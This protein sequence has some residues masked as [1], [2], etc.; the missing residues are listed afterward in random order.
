MKAILA[1]SG[2]VSLALL[3]SWNVVPASLASSRPPEWMGRLGW[4]LVHSLWQLTGVAVIAALLEIFLRRRSANVRYIAAVAVLAAMVVPPCVT[5]TLIDVSQLAGTVAADPIGGRL[6]PP[7]QPSEKPAQPIKNSS[8]SRL[9][10]ALPGQPLAALDPNPSRK[11]GR[12]TSPLPPEVPSNVI[13]PKAEAVEESMGKRVIFS[14]EIPELTAWELLVERARLVVEPNLPRLVWLWLAG[15][16]VCSLRPVWGLWIQWQL[17]RIGLSPVSDELQRT[18]LQLTRR[19]GL[20]RV[21]RLAES[22]CVTVPMVVGYVRPMILLPASVL[23]GLSLTQLE[24]LLAHELAHVRRHDWLINAM[25]VVVETL[26][27]YHP[28]VWWLSSR[29]RNERE[30]CCDDIALAVLGDRATYARMLLTVEELRDAKPVIAIAGPSLFAATGGD[31]VHRVR[32]LLPAGSNTER[33]SRG[34]LSGSLLLLTLGILGGVSVFAVHGQN[35]TTSKQPKPDPAIAKDVPDNSLK[36]E[37]SDNRVKDVAEEESAVP[38]NATTKPKKTTADQKRTVRVVDESK[39]PIAGATVRFQFEGQNTIFPGFSMFNDSAKTN[40]KGEYSEEIP[41]GAERVHITVKADGFGEF[42]DGQP[43]SA[44]SSVVELKKGRVIR[45]RAVDSEHKLLK[46]AVPLLSNNRTFGREFVPQPDGTFT[47]PPVALTRRMMRVCA[48]QENGPT[49]FSELID[50]ATAKPG[51]DGVIEL[52]LKPGVRLTGRLADAVPR[53]IS[54]GYVDLFIADG[55][56]H[57]FANDAFRWEDSTPVQTDG[58]F[59]FESIPGG[60]HAQFHVVVDGYLSVNPTSESILEYVQTYHAAS[61]QM[62]NQYREM[63]KD[64]L[65]EMWPRFVRLDRPEVEVTVECEKTAS[66]D[67]HIVDS[68]GNP[69]PNAVV[70][71]SPNGV[72]LSCGL[73]IPGAQT[74]SSAE[75]VD[76]LSRGSATINVFGSKDTSPRAVRQRKEREWAEKSFLR[77]KSDAQGRVQ[78]RNLPGHGRESFSV[79]ADGYVLPRSPLYQRAGDERDD[80]RREGYVNLIAGE[81]N[82]ATITLERDLKVVEREVLMVDDKGRPQSKVTVAVA[83]MRVGPKDWQLWSTQ[84]FG[85]LPKEVTDENGRVLLK[86]PSLIGNTQV[87]RLRLA[88]NYWSGRNDDRIWVNGGLVEAPLI[89]DE[90]VIVLVPNSE[91]SRPGNVVYGKLEDILPK[92]TTE[93]LLAVM[94]EQPSLAVLRQLLGATKTKQPEP[95]ELLAEKRFL[96]GEKTMQV[97]QTKVI[98]SGDSKLAVVAARVRPADGTR[99]SVTDPIELPECAFVFDMQ[100][101]L[102]AA[103]GGHVG[104]TGA[105]SPD[106]IDVLSLG[107]E[108]DWFV[109]TVRFQESGAFEYQTEYYR[110][111]NPV[112]KSLKYIHYANSNGWST[113]PEKITRWGTLSF[114]FP[115]SKDKFDSPGHSGDGG[116]AHTA[117]GVPVLRTMTWD[118]DRNLFIGAAAQFGKGKPLYQVDLDWSREFLPIDLKSNQLFVTGGEREYDHW[119]GWHTVVPDQ[120]ELLLTIT[121]PQTKGEPKVIEKRLAPGKRHVQ[122]QLKPNKD[123]SSARLELRL[124]SI[125]PEMMELP[126]QLGDRPEKHPPMTQILNPGDSARLLDRK[127]KSSTNALIVDIK[128]Q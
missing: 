96:G 61:E 123:N 28:A 33:A 128:L 23:T 119:H 24:L 125:E 84:R 121:I 22:V 78:I 113:G 32:R 105:G 6:A 21:I 47:S 81:T 65:H 76:T 27:F 118:G 58:T 13:L 36:Q 12:T 91:T 107:P 93:Q 9:P 40:E 80:H 126:I 30:L 88:V 14:K 73:F 97:F 120:H 55:P 111:A 31:L 2:G 10:P 52:V 79:T 25:Q 124:D 39:Q 103:V 38:S 90:G 41:N 16:A 63:L 59:T 117:D 50:V 68:A 42:N 64:R 77:A 66:C 57:T 95:I 7:V 17:R 106:N 114:D 71:F 60:G 5:W 3:H 99:D 87:Q 112:V 18:L 46:Q 20:T 49:L 70:S 108:E 72:T 89:A 69:I 109:R 127:L 85:T 35:E 8:E 43:A 56:G 26:F 11:T 82:E 54:E 115:N 51:A 75:L 86:I 74:Y 116:P 45:V 83:E 34:W 101:K 92:Q 48:A 110:I 15:V 98:L 44:G 122:M 53:P 94:I 100:G 67:F 4:T 62:L 29:I 104:T 1:M 102:V 37:A 19:M